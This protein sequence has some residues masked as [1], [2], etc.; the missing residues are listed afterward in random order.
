MFIIN[1]EMSPV[2]CTFQYAVHLNGNNFYT[3]AQNQSDSLFSVACHVI[4]WL[5]KPLRYLGTSPCLHTPR[6]TCFQDVLLWILLEFWGF[7]SYLIYCCVAINNS[8]IDTVKN[9]S[10]QFCCCKSRLNK[11]CNEFIKCGYSYSR[12]SC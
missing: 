9:T 3:I 11:I 4:L 6:M 2:W 12:A 7:A 5:P 1:H 8:K 10:G